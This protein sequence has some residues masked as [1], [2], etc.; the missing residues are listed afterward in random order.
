M[1][2]RCRS[3]AARQTRPGTNPNARKIMKS[4]VTALF[5]SAL[6]SGYGLLAPWSHPWLLDGIEHLGLYDLKV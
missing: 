5:V 3:P 2:L 1:V 4:R 6:T